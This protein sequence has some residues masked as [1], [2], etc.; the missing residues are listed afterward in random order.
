MQL[1][2]FD[3]DSVLRKGA[4]FFANTLAPTSLSPTG[5]CSDTAEN[6]KD[7]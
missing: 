7:K 2:T 1:T 3:V 5:Q 6:S 4:I